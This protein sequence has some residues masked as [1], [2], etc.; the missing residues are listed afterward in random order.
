MGGL[1]VIS[2]A[3][4]NPYLNHA[5]VISTSALLG[6]PKDQKMNFMK[7]Y[8]AKALEKKIEDIIINSMIHPTTLTKIMNTSRNALEISL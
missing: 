1:L 2:L 5:G 6:F 3:I 7:A 8:L 4:R